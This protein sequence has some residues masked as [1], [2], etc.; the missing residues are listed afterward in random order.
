MN[1]VSQETTPGAHQSC[2]QARPVT[3][4]PTH[5]LGARPARAARRLRHRR[6]E[7]CRLTLQSRTRVGP[8]AGWMRGSWLD[9]AGPRRQG[10]SALI[11][12]ESPEGQERKWYSWPSSAR[13]L[14]RRFSHFSEQ[15][16]GLRAVS[17]GRGCRESAGA[18]PRPGAG[19]KAASRCQSRHGDAGSRARGG[20][21]GRGRGLRAPVRKRGTG[22]PA[23]LAGPRGPAGAQRPGEGKPSSAA[24]PRAAGLGPGRAGAAGPAEPASTGGGREVKEASVL[25]LCFPGPGLKAEPRCHT[26]FRGKVPARASPRAAAPWAQSGA[27]TSQGRAQSAGGPEP[28]ELRRR[29]A[30]AARRARRGRSGRPGPRGLSP[31]GTKESPGGRGG[32]AASLG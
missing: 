18:G 31:R 20:R 1:G 13:P 27:A 26:G 30:G 19:W 3:T 8:R 12:V 23:S 21:K 25:S 10:R 6:A 16:R 32:A 4:L 15:L 14:V 17:Q 2:L 28:R 9:G 11:G 29:G 22:S 7:G 24:V 5:P